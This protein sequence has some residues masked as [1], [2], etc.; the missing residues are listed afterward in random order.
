M[1]IVTTV[2]NTQANP[3]NISAKNI[4]RNTE[5]VDI[6]LK[7]DSRFACLYL[8]GCG[9][10]KRNNMNISIIVMHIIIHATFCSDFMVINTP[11]ITGNKMPIM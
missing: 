5:V 6:F 11:N 3:R 4:F 1:Y 9:G 2:S 8:C 7:N 10:D